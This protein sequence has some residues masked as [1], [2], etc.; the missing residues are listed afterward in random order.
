LRK[1]IAGDWKNNFSEEAK[2]VF[3]A[4]AGSELIKMGYEKDDSWV[5]S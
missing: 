5:K 3:H 4:Y 1:G 2:Q